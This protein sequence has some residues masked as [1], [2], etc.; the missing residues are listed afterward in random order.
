M[1]IATYTRSESGTLTRT[2]ENWNNENEARD[3]YANL[4][5]VLPGA[6]ER[7]LG[8]TESRIQWVGKIGLAKAVQS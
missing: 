6:C 5:E 1:Q 8:W 3:Y 7:L 2:I 4:Q